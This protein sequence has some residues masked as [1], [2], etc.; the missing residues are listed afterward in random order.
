[1]HVA[2]GL[3]RNFSPKVGLELVAERLLLPDVPRNSRVIFGGNPWV[4]K[5]FPESVNLG[6]GGIHIVVCSFAAVDTHS[7]VPPS[8]SQLK[9]PTS[10]GFC[11]RWLL[12]G[13]E[14]ARARIPKTIIKDKREV[15]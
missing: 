2:P 15:D 9:Y 13:A 11:W 1:M 14:I 5:S 7:L 6:L 3:A 8:C 4:G 10:T 12:E